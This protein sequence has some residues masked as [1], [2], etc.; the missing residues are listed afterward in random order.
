MAPMIRN[1]SVP[2]TT[3]GGSRVSGDSCERC[4]EFIEH[5]PHGWRNGEFQRDL[6]VHMSQRAEMRREYDA[7]HG[8]VCHLD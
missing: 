5:R 6:A 1:G 7:N 3:S 2:A 4:F 8:S